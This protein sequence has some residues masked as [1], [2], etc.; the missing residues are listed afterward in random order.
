MEK[1]RYSAK[2][3]QITLGIG[4]TKFWNEV[5][6]G[7]LA[8]YFDGNKAYCTAET[9]KRYDAECQTHTVCPGGRRAS[10]GTKGVQRKPEAA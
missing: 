8:V 4:T 3:A 6:A 2:E 7:R 9:L 1:L 10:P 5:R